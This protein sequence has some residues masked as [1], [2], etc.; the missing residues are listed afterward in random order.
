[1]F[2]ALANTVQSGFATGS[3][4]EPDALRA[5]ILTAGGGVILTVA[6]WLMFQIFDAY[7]DQR[8]TVAD[9]VWGTLKT[10]VIASL[11]LWAMFS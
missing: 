4:V 2:L 7:K 6:A 5:V 8:V 9:A 1:M 11:L 3:G 10:A